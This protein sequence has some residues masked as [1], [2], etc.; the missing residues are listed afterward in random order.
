MAV[1]K[2]VKHYPKELKERVFQEYEGSES[3]GVLSRKYGVSLLFCR[4]LVRK[5]TGGESALGS[6]AEKEL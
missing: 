2:G 5:A 1:K 4:K 6:T 3:M